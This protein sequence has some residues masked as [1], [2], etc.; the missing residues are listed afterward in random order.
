MPLAI[1]TSAGITG[2]LQHSADAV[3][4]GRGTDPTAGWAWAPDATGDPTTAT[5]RARDESGDVLD[6]F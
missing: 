3:F 5:V 6:S 4:N 2:A 1:G